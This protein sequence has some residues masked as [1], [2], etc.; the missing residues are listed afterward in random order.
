MNVD[1]GKD[2]SFGAIV[3]ALD[4][5]DPTGPAIAWA[6]AEAV[7]RGRPLHV[8]A[9]GDHD[10]PE[11]PLTPM[12]HLDSVDPGEALELAA[13][14][15][16]E[17]APGLEVRTTGTLG[18]LVSLLLHASQT[19]DTVV[20]AGRGTGRLHSIFLGSTAIQVASHASCPVVV[21]PYG[22]QQVPRGP[23]VVGVD[24]SPLSAEAVGYAYLQAAERGVGLTV[25]HAWQVDPIEESLGY[26]ASDTWWSEF[27][28]P[29]QVLTAES[30]A[31]WG[32]K[33]PDVVVRRRIVR[34]AAVDTIVAESE[35]AGLVVVGSRGWGDFRG[36]LLGSV[37]QGVIRR[38]H[39]PV[40]V[41]RPRVPAVVS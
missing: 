30:L 18:R 10:Y 8:V 19:A 20:V 38:V 16:V 40:A 22:A 9:T 2:R 32:E 14:K 27:S 3:V 7:R 36:T 6:V 15:I 1:K 17:A 29:E 26:A 41:V 31:G 11:S 24:G 28:N 25:V 23:V 5:L 39:R 37:S 4:G 34:G 13:A 35:D 33:Y 21:V 12:T